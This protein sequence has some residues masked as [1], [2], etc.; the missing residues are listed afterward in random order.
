M[1]KKWLE[2]LPADLQKVVHGDAAAVSKKII[3]FMY[4]FIAAQHKEWTDEGGVMIDLP[5]DEQAA[6]NAKLSSIGDDLS[7]EDPELNKAVKLA[8]ESVAR[9]R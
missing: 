5:A 3:P 4:E 9:N 7:K 6:L 2:A 1:N 8:V